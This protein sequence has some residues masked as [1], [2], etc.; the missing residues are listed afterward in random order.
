MIGCVAGRAVAL[1]VPG[2]GI[3]HAVRQ[4]HAGVAEADA[5]VG[6]RQQHLGARLIIGRILHG[7]HQVA[8][9]DA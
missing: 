3:R 4:V 6:R 1:H 7:A 2:D 9:D 5:R 8:I